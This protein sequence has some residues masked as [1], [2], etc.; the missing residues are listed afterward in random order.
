MII[1]GTADK[2]GTAEG[3]L[4]EGSYP[5]GKGQT[6][7]GER[8]EIIFL[9]QGPKHPSTQ[10]VFRPFQVWS[11]HYCLLVHLVIKHHAAV[12]PQGP[13]R[14]VFA[15]RPVGWTIEVWAWKLVL[16]QILQNVGGR[17]LV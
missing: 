6:K 15:E 3:I 2:T 12:R 11:S 9:D 14:T 7:A 8:Q 4:Q 17:S 10:K 13:Q 16:D 5:G 1:A